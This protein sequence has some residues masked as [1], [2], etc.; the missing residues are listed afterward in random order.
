VAE[1]TTLTQLAR[2]LCHRWEQ[3]VAARDK[4]RFAEEIGDD[5]TP[6][7]MFYWLTQDEVDDE[8]WERS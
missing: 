8:R 6:R 2:I 3:I 4:E 5:V 7:N 1:E